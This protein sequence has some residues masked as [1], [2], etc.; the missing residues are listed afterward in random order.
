MKFKYQI[1]I[2]AMLF[3]S[4]SPAQVR[5]IGQ[6]HDLSKQNNNE[7]L[8]HENQVYREKQVKS[9]SNNIYLGLAYSFK[10]SSEISFVLNYNKVKSTAS[11]IETDLNNTIRVR[12]NSTSEGSS[13][14]FQLAYNKKEVISPKF[15]VLIPIGLRTGYKSKSYTHTDGFI[16]DVQGNIGRYDKSRAIQKAGFQ[17]IG[18]YSGMEVYYN[19]YKGFALGVGIYG[20]ADYVFDSLPISVE[21]Q[22][23][24]ANYNQISQN[25][26]TLQ[27]NRHDIR[28]NKQLFIGLR[29]EF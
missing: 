1:I 6:F 28:F 18:I 5:L 20:G 22:S 9:F 27:T 14:N 16:Y 11:N 25:I 21:D 19:L 4:E 23:Y 24:F 26:Y 10:K 15:Y 3:C 8:F 29:Y 17:S 12:Q 2:V 13:I 7:Q